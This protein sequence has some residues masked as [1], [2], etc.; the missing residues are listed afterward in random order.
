MTMGQERDKKAAPRRR[1]YR[2]RWVWA[3]VLLAAAF[4]AVVGPWPTYS[5]HF[6]G[7]GY[8][9]A[10]FARVDRM[11]PGACVGPLR[12]GAAAVDITPP[13]GEPMAGYGA[14]EPKASRGILDRLHAKA[15][16][17]TNG[18][19]CVTIVGG[20]VLLISPGLREAI[21]A[22]VG[23]P[24]EEVYFTATH[25]HTGPGGYSPRW[26]YR[27]VLGRYDEKI[28]RRLAGAFA[29]AVR[30]SR[31]NMAAA[32]VRY[33][34][35]RDDPELDSLLFNRLLNSP[36]KGSLSGLYLLRRDGRPLACVVVLGAHPTNLERQDRRI[37]GDY[38]GAVQRAIERATGAVA[39]FAQ[40][41]VGSMRLAIERTRDAGAFTAAGGKIAAVAAAGFGERGPA[42]QAAATVELAAAIVPVDLPP[43]QYRIS[44]HWRLSPIACGL[45]HDRRTYVHVLRINEAVFLGMPGDMSGELADELERWSDGRPLSPVVTSFN[46]DYIGYLVP[47]RHYG[48]GNYEVRKT[49]LFGPWCGAYFWELS[50][51]IMK[52]MAARGAEVSDSRWAAGGK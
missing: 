18:L 46:G 4:V 49:N 7:S 44:E 33:V 17:L 3:A 34:Q 2:R 16:S 5:S 6:A 14:R 15:V 50:R 51:R 32:R 13:V 35:V 30:R 20:D 26:P 22:R 48:T 52:R 42:G 28:L 1:F 47:Q 40:G 10:T 25:T 31:A 38:P 43:Q 37:S 19:K 23:L 12:A 9:S 36:G 11:S 39:L 27:P 21:L 41:G 45:L 24:R 8:A 29:E